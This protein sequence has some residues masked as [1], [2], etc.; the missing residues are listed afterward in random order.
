MLCPNC[1]QQLPDGA[2][3]CPMCGVSFVQPQPQQPSASQ[4]AAQQELKKKSNQG[5]LVPIMSIGLGV[6]FLLLGIHLHVCAILGLGLI[7]LGAYSLYK[8]NSEL[9]DLKRVSSGAVKIGVC[10]KC[11]SPNIEMQMV[12]AGAYT[13]QSK[14][15]VSEN[16]NPLKPFTHV[17]VN[18]GPSTTINKFKNKGHCLNCGFVFDK[19][20]QIY[21]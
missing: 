11:K 13:S 16:I 7:G 4:L 9:S 6:M 17:N 1:N 5:L 20:L 18:Q 15:T 2:K 19:P 21:Q 10:P 12:Q 3:A 14:T 8:R